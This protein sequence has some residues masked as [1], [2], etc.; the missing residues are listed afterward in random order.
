MVTHKNFR[1]PCHGHKD[2]VDTASERSQEDLA[3]L[4]TNYKGKCHDDSSKAA[5]GVVAWL[6]KLKVQVCQQSAKVRDKNGAHTQHR[7][8]KT[9]V[10]QRVDTTVLHHCPCVFGSWNVCLA[11][12]SNVAEGIPVEE[13]DQPVEQSDEAAKNPNGDAANNVSPCSFLLLRNRARLADHV[14]NGNDQTSKADTTKGIRSRTFKG[15]TSG[16][17]GSTA[18]SAAPEIPG[19][20]HTSDSGMDGVL[21]PFA[22]PIH[23]KGNIDNKP[24]NL[25]AA[26][27]VRTARWI[28]PAAIG[29][30]CDVD[31][32][33]GDR[34][35]CRESNGGQATKCANDK[36]VA[37]GA[38]HVNRSLQ[39]DDTEWNT[40]NPADETDDSENTEDEE[41]DAGAPLLPVEIVDRSADSK[42]TV[43]NAG[44]PDKLLGKIAGTQEIR[45]RH[46]ESDTEHKDEQ[47]QRVGVQAK[48]IARTVDASTIEAPVVRVLVDGKTRDGD[49]AEENSNELG[50]ASILEAFFHQK[51]SDKLTKR[52][53]Q[54]S[55]NFGFSILKASS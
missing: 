55:L 31:R 6:G 40:R 52:P 27:S 45:P 41:H 22:K 7:S 37:I 28:R 25:G 3:H 47:N 42:D 24:D 39:H 18:R 21:D 38:R 12:Q 17:L 23:S 9:V 14:D 46:R 36:N 30:V 34:K 43:K 15:A 35:P 51:T 11:I 8:N 2:G 1:V 13:G 20:V 33:Q 10:D 44:D 50:G 4:K 26:A 32:D 48:I 53:A 54:M 19:S 49:I 16:T 29:F 5:I